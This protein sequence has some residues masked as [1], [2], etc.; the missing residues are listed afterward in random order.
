MKI[1]LAGCEGYQFAKLIEILNH[2]N[3]LV[4]YYHIDKSEKNMDLLR[5]SFNNRGFEIICDSGLFTLMFGAGKGGTHSLHSMA[6]YTRDYISWAKCSGLTDTTYVESDVHKLLGMKAVY[7]LRKQFEDSGLNVMYVWH[8]EEGI[9][10]LLR[11][12]ERYSYVALSVPELR[13]LFKKHNW[14][15]QDAV[16]DL[17]N[18]I[19]SE[20][21]VMPKIHLLGNTVQETMQT[22][23]AYS[24]DSTSWL[25]GGRWGRV[26][27]FE[28][29]RLFPILRKSNKYRGYVT[30][31]R[32]HFPEFAAKIELHTKEKDTGSL[33]EYMTSN[34]ISAQSLNLFEQYLNKFYPWVGLKEGYNGNKSE[35]VDSPN[36]ISGTEPMESQPTI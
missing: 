27:V 20:V 28:N 16:F 33:L 34:Y 36:R 24:C 7:E 22:P 23:L 12:C 32:D 15:Y 35:C 6:E 17:L 8:R 1:F 25:S 13:V 11:M 14:R 19:R 30:K 3:L 18:K 9:D 31:L 2:K 10:G 5:S 26:I 21:K 4:S 29:G